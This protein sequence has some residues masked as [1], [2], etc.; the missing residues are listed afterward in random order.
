LCA[1]DG[2]GGEATIDV[3][4]TI[5]PRNDPPVATAAPEIAYVTAGH[6]SST[7]HASTGTWNDDRDLAPGTITY[8]VQWQRAV[9]ASGSSVS[10]IAGA[11]SW[12][13]TTSSA[14]RGG[15]LRVR[16]RATDDGEGEPVTASTEATSS[17]VLEPSLG[18]GGDGSSGRKCGA[19][20]GLSAFALV[21]L[22]SVMSL[23]RQR[24]R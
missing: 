1:V 7:L 17:F 5:C 4:V 21:I 8:A 22:L 9:D 11:T 18:G 6:H 20:G 15:F 10:D 13:Y 2:F 19:G 16:V 14:D 3:A 12:E 24:R 23:R